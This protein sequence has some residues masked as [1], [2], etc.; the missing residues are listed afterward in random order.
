MLLPTAASFTINHLNH[1]LNSGLAPVRVGS[2]TRT[3][4][5]SRVPKLNAGGGAA[6]GVEQY[7]GV[8][9]GPPPDL[10]SLLLHNRIVYI[11]MPLVPAVTELIIAELLYLNYE[12]SDKPIYM[13][14]NSSGT[15]SQDGRPVG[16]ETE[17]ERLE[18]RGNVCGGRGTYVKAEAA[19]A[20]PPRRQ[21][22]TADPTDTADAPS[23]HTHTHTHTLPQLPS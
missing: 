13:Y 17:G 18:R 9:I 7:D 23:T 16:F 1:H 8:R 11:G 14:I 2:P 10:P 5:L 20:E 19:L 22:F 15:L 21:F 4:R 3:K 12:S 6:A